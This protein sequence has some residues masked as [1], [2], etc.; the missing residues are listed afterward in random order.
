[1]RPLRIVSPPRPGGAGGSSAGSVCDL[2]SHAH[3]AVEL[4]A[5]LMRTIARFDC[6]LADNNC[7]IRTSRQRQQYTYSAGSL[8]Q[9][10]VIEKRVCTP[11]CHRRNSDD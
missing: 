11:V 5:Q 10:P 7:E 4:H 3:L 8:L 9:T 6:I 2:S 1:M